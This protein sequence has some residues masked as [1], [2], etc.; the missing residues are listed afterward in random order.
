MLDHITYSIVIATFNGSKTIERCLNSIFSQDFSKS[1]EVIVVDSSHDNT[2]D[3]IQNQFPGVILISLDKQTPEGAARNIG[4]LKARGDFIAMTDQDCVVEPDW[5]SRT[6]MIMQKSD[7]DAVGG[8]VKPSHEDDLFGRISF[9]VEFSEFLPGSKP[10]L[11]KSMPTCN[12]IYRK[13]VFQNGHR[14]VEAYPVSEDWVFNYILT[15]NGGQLYFDPDITIMH[16]N[17]RGLHT[18]LR[19]Q[20]YLGCGSA[21]ARIILP[22]LPGAHVVRFPVFV[23]LLPFYR[24]FAVVIRLARLSRRHFFQS[25]LAGPLIFLNIV[26]WSAGFSFQTLKEMMRGQGIQS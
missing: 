19:H 15:C 25:I 26:A 24:W 20:Y 12:I 9:L 21:H 14:F 10:G 23:L 4:I 13:R 7:Y 2:S 3:I 11:K 6:D 22:R 8:S 16:L 5:L 1:F 18:S 17:R